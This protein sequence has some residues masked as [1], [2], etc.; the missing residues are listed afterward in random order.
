MCLFFVE[1]DQKKVMVN[2]KEIIEFV[3][4]LEME[5]VVD[6]VFCVFGVFGIF[7]DDLFFFY[8]LG[9]YVICF[10]LG[11]MGNEEFIMIFNLYGLKIEINMS[12]VMK[13]VDNILSY[14][15]N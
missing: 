6:I 4:E 13:Y 3:N 9:V 2:F 14:R 8:E 12:N 11:Y 7:Y 5:V 1:G 10:D 15:L